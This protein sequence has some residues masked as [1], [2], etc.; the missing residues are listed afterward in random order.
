MIHTLPTEQYNQDVV[1]LGTHAASTAF[2]MTALLRDCA[3]M[4][5]IA[6][7]QALD[8]RDASA[9]LGAGNRA[10]YQ[11]LRSIV[12]FMDKDRPFDSDIAAVSELIRTRALPLPEAR[13]A[14]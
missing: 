5:L 10:V 9:H 8:L 14:P 13:S 1:S 4:L 3:A 12:R 2:D 7:C 6:V 11:K